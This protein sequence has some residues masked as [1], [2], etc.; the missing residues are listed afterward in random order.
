M[1]RPSHHLAIVLVLAFLG[2]APLLACPWHKSKQV[3]GFWG[4]SAHATA[5]ELEELFGPF[6]TTGTSVPVAGT[7]SEVGQWLPPRSWPVIA[8]HAALLPTGDVLHYSYP[9]GGLGSAAMTWNP[10]TDQFTDVSFDT[11]AFCSG[12]SQLADGTLYVTGGNDTVC[13]FQGRTI[14]NQFDPFTGAWTPLE[15]MVTGRWYPSNLEL[16]DGRTLIL[17]GLDRTCEL[18]PE[19]E[20]FTPGQGLDVVPGGLRSVALYPRL[21]LLTSGLVA[22]VGPEQETSTFD[23]ALEQW[24]AVTSMAVPGR[25]DGTSFLV[26]GYPDQIVTCGGSGD[27]PPTDSCERIDFSQATPQW[28]PTSSMTFARSHADALILPDR[29]VLVV[30]GGTDGLYGNPVL[31][32]EAYDPDS[33]QWTVLPP[34]VNGR[35]YHATTVLLP[36]GRVLLAGQDSGASSLSAEIYQPSYL[37]SGPRPTVSAVPAEIIYGRDFQIATPDAGDVTS[38]ALIG[39]STVTHSVNTGQRYVGLGFTA[40]A[41]SLAVTAP[42]D[43]NHAPPGYYMLFV[44]SSAGVPSVAEIIRLGGPLI[45]TDGFESGDVSAWSAT[46]P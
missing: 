31:N 13:Q 2:T 8:I 14:T 24:S 45:F 20:V 38:V 7:P 40:G 16:G 4:P 9:D 34:H 39:L 36:D 23:P 25:W 10:A 15:D 35:M 12:L 6:D 21:H 27:D 46:V 1:S 42:I 29:R 28:T 32:P 5:E 33:G 37:F 3:L 43:G 26:P 44:L 18:A 30:G 41:G 17:S 19:M 11:D 22:H